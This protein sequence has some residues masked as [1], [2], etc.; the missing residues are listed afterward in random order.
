MNQVLYSSPQC[1]LGFGSAEKCIWLQDFCLP[2]AHT[3]H[4]F[5]VC[6]LNIRICFTLK[7]KFN[8]GLREAWE[9]FSPILSSKFSASEDE[10][11]NLIQWACL[12][13]SAQAYL[14]GPFNCGFWH[15][16]EDVYNQEHHN[17]HLVYVSGTST[18]RLWFTGKLGPSTSYWLSAHALSALTLAKSLLD[19][20]GSEAQIN[21][22]C[23]VYKKRNRTTLKSYRKWWLTAGTQA[24]LSTCYSKLITKCL[25]LKTK[26]MDYRV[27]PGFHH[28]ILKHLFFSRWKFF[29]GNSV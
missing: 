14:A 6:L 19:D 15:W 10:E 1:S 22:S 25:F 13:Y 20:N 5:T 26:G 28:E 4:A 11:S 7:K 24:P 23:L 18:Q 21:R 8:L 16:L 2:R 27:F 12:P 3:W 29:Q 17:A 9:L